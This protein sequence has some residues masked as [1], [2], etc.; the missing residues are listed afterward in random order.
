MNL[1][2]NEFSSLCK[3]SLR[4]KGH[5]WGICEDLSNALLALALNRF[6]APNILLEALNTENGKLIQIFSIVDSKAYEASDKINGKFFDPI[7]IL[8]LIS[9]HRD[10]KMP[11]LEVA[12]DNEVFILADNLIIG[13]R[14]Y[15]RKKIN[16]IAFCKKEPSGIVKHDFVTRVVIDDTTLKAIE[17]WSNLTYAPATEQSRNLGAGSEISDND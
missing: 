6:P 7:L 1:S 8:G 9:V 5:H 11:S 3:R 13:N 2:K 4:G 15:S 17:Y 14:S 12:L 10:L 16:T